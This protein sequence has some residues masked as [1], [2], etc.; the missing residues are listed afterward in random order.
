MIQGWRNS[1][2]SLLYH[3]Q[4]ANTN[5]R[6]KINLIR[7]SECVFLVKKIVCRR[8]IEYTN[9][10]NIQII[11]LVSYLVKE[12]KCIYHNC[13]GS[14]LH[15]HT[16]WGYYPIVHQH[17]WILATRDQHGLDSC[18]L[19]KINSLSLYFL[20]IWTAL[21]S[22]QSFVTLHTKCTFRFLY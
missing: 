8:L 4:P 12:R 3:S 15:I 11:I 10:H 22:P 19:E 2:W 9:I 6:N 1:K 20:W 17:K 18:V 5:D 21:P 7:I 14:D 13:S 16:S